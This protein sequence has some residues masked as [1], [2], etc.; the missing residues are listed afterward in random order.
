MK[1]IRTRKPTQ[2]IDEMRENKN[3]SHEHNYKI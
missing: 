2:K 3:K 1:S